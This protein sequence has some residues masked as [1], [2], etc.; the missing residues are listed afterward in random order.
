MKKLHFHLV[1]A[2]AA[3][4]SIHAADALA[5]ADYGRMNGER[6]S[7]QQTATQDDRDETETT[8]ANVVIVKS[9]RKMYLLDKDE[10]ILRTYQI[11]LGPNPTGHKQKE[12]DGRTPEGRYYIDF[13]NTNSEYLLSLRISYPS[14][15]DKQRARRAGVNPGGAIFIHGEP[16]DR[17]WMFWKYS[18]KNDWTQGCIAVNN[19]DIQE[20]WNLVPKGTPVIIQP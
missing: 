12:G 10:N 20:I 14:P 7:S 6:F 4:V 9:E 5:Q 11:A 2:F 19:K 1:L 17:N 3:F 8:V 15:T 13:R 16:P 18:N